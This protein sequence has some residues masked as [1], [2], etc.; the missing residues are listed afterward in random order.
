MSLTRERI[1]ELGE[2][3]IRTKGYNAFSYQ[4]ISSA[5]GI[6]NAAVHYYFPTK[7]NLGT[8]IVKTNIQRF[9]EMIGNMQSRG[10]DEAKQLEAFIKIY[11]KSHR[12]QKLCIVGSLGPAFNTL[13]ESTQKELIKI[14][15]IIQKWLVD[16]LENGRKKKIFE[17]KEDPSYK[18]NIIF[19]SLVASLQISRVTNLLDYKQLS[20]NIMNDLNP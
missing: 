17:F 6:K 18:A 7:A 12:E 1:L 11:I 20:Q 14:T 19:S 16:V 2:D 4:D 8:S 3:L 13:D 10:F 5:L 9:E 15:E